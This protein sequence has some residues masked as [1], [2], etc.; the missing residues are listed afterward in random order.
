MNFLIFLWNSFVKA[1]YFISFVILEIVVFQ[2][3]VTAVSDSGMPVLASLLTIVFIIWLIIELIIGV[4]VGGAKNL[5]RY[6][7][8][9]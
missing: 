7:F 8:R 5:A 3:I 4:F 9:F 6:I 2:L 1:I